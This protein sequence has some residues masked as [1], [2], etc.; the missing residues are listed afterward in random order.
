[1]HVRLANCHCHKSVHWPLELAMARLVKHQL[2]GWLVEFRSSGQS[3][4]WPAVVAVKMVAAIIMTGAAHMAVDRPV[5]TMPRAIM[6]ADMAIVVHVC[7]VNWLMGH[8]TLATSASNA[9]IGLP[10]F[11]ANCCKWKSI[12]VVGQILWLVAMALPMAM[13]PP[14]AMVADNELVIVDHGSSLWVAAG[15]VVQTSLSSRILS[16]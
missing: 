1:M 8:R 12:A 6:A 11:S 14:M 9:P 13:G 5:V 3:A 2:G 10:D 15:S 7:R 16:F 4:K